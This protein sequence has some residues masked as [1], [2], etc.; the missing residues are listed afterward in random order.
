MFVR[1]LRVPF[2]A[3]VALVAGVAVVAGV[4]LIAGV[5]VVLAA[6]LGV[7]RILILLDVLAAKGTGLLR[8]HHLAALVLHSQPLNFISRVLSIVLQG[9]ASAQLFLL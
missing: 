8:R 7:G 1:T 2:V 6:F 5:A 9:K 3:G 4:A